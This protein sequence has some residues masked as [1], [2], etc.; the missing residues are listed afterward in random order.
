MAARFSLASEFPVLLI[1]DKHQANLAIGSFK[2]CFDI[3]GSKQEVTKVFT[4][5]KKWQKYMELNQISLNTYVIFIFREKRTLGGYLLFSELQLICCS[6]EPHI[7]VYTMGEI[8]VPMH[9]R[10]LNAIANR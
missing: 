10:G 1:S 9:K 6:G 7:R 8:W 5:E 2:H 4:S 3:P